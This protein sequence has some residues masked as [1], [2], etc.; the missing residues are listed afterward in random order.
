MLIWVAAHVLPR[1]E[2]MRT[3]RRNQPGERQRVA[4][5]MPSVD[6]LTGREL[7]AAVQREVMGSIVGWILMPNGER[8]PVFVPRRIDEPHLSD[9]PKWVPHYS[10]QAREAATLDRSIQALG[11]VDLYER[12]VLGVNARPEDKCRAALIAVRAARA[13]DRLRVLAS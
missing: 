5:P 10:T 11:L 3:R 6:V 12:N 4:P 13:I 2:T 7:D 1:I 9:Q 8:E